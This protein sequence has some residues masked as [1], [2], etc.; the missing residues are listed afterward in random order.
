[1]SK[2]GIAILTITD[3]R[4]SENDTSG[5]FLAQA[6]S[7][8]GHKLSAREICKDDKYVI[9]ARLSHWLIQPDVEIII[10]NGGTGVTGRD[11]T[12]EAVLPL[13]DKEITGFGELFRWLSY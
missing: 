9:R 2:L 8:A 3:T 5:A 11:I 6:I 12:V 1:L 13:L 10:T 4:T 7:E